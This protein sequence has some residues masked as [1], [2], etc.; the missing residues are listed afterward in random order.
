MRR[1]LRP[2]STARGQSSGG[3]GR[4]VLLLLLLAA[5]SRTSCVDAWGVFGK[6]DG[7]DGIVHVEGAMSR[8]GCSVHQLLPV[9]SQ[10]DV[11]SRIKEL[12]EKCK[13]APASGGKRLSLRVSRW[14]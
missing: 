8:R 1:L 4:A 9:H 10:D 13:E 14:V 2:L 7:G 3:G 6:K 11:I 5:L 12:N